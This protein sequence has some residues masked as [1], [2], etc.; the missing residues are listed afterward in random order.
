M[1]PDALQKMIASGEV[2]SAEDM[3]AM[4]TQDPNREQRMT[5]MLQVLQAIQGQTPEMN[6]DGTEA[7][8][9]NLVGTLGPSDMT[10]TKI[11]GYWYIK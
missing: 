5:Q 1:P 8:F 9:P 2:A 3:A 10:F 6:A 7:K 4:L 11:D